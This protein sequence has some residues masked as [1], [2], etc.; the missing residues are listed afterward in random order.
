MWNLGL[1]NTQDVKADVGRDRTSEYGARFG[2]E[3]VQ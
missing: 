3:K 1:K 2:N